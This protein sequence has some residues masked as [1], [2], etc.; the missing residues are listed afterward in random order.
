MS[1]VAFNVT[2]TVE[3]PFGDGDS[4]ARLY[5]PIPDESVRSK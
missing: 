2:D 1:G 4:N 3:I 5:V